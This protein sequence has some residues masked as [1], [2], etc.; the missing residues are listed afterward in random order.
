[1]ES[2]ACVIPAL[3]EEQALPLVLREI[4]R[5]LVKRVVVADNGSTD[6]TAEVAREHG[7]EVV[8]ER[9]RGYGAA[10]LKAL[11]HLAAD[12]PD[13]VVFLDGDYSDHPSELPLLLEPI[14][15]GEA[16]LVIGSRARGARERGALSAQQ[17]V[18]NAIACTAL[19]L[20]YGVRY[21]DL[22]P[23]RAIRWDALRALGMCDRDYGWTVEMQIKAARQG[24]AYGEVPVSYRRRVGVSKVSGTVKGSVS[25]GAKILWLLG[26]Y[27]WR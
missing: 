1:M 14:A 19:R 24:M 2:V 6:R 25:A 16:E 3:N 4:P 8:C 12:P 27:A 17:Q 9:E 7:A 23:F 11:A 15:N 22:G 13:V 5:P 10:C 20:L 18:G 26:R 21:T